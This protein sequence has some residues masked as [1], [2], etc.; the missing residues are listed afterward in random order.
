MASSLPLLKIPL[1]FASA[2]L[3][4]AGLTPPNP[5]AKTIEANRFGATD[6][7]SHRAAVLWSNV[8]GES[9]VIL[10]SHSD[11]PLA[12]RVL[13]I[14]VPAVAPTATHIRIT[15]TF[16]LGCILMCAG[17]FTR[18]ACH[19]EL[20]Q[21]FTWELSLRNNHKLVTTGPYAVVRH[22]S[23]T[24][25]L[26]MGIGNVLGLFGAGSWWRECGLW[27]TSL[28]KTVA[29]QWAAEWLIAPALIVWRVRVEDE[30]LRK[31]FREQWDAWAQKT[32]YR[33]IPYVF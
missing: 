32:Q 3:T 1:L 6:I 19:R 13:S 20:G 30:V 31:E 4:H 15:S 16:L 18:I 33:L 27:A 2:T 9:A 10:A 12:Q 5:P 28:G 21:Y 24:G 14:L 25:L 17:G 29:V 7:L 23:Y 22:P 26:M 11:S 8:L